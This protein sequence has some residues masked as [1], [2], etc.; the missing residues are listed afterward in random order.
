MSFVLYAP[1]TF[2]PAMNLLLH[3]HKNTQV[4]IDDITVFSSTF[5]EH[6]QH[7][8]NPFQ[9]TTWQNCLRKTIQMYTRATTNRILW[10]HCWTKWWANTTW[11]PST[12]RW[13]E[14]TTKCTRH[15]MILRPHWF[16]STVHKTLHTQS[17][18]TNLNPPQN[19]TIWI[20]TWTRNLV[21]NE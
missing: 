1:A 4:F 11:K 6:Y 7:L 12:R 17:W 15:T 19:Y 16:L 10:L 13:L 2:Q 20:D 21:S 5:E 18:T 3:D 9:E 14:N 8:T